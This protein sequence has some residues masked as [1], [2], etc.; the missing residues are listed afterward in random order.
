[1]EAEKF[2]QAAQILRHSSAK[3]RRRGF[4][5]EQTE[6]TEGTEKLQTPK[7]K[8]RGSTK[9]QTPIR[10]GDFTRGN[11]GN[12]E[13][14]RSSEFQVSPSTIEKRRVSLNICNRRH[15]NC[16]QNHKYDCEL[17]EHRYQREKHPTDLATNC[18]A[19]RP[20]HPLANKQSNYRDEKKQRPDKRCGRA[21][22]ME[23]VGK[24]Q[25]QKISGRAEEDGQP[26]DCA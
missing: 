22:D 25:Q 17:E 5:Q 8:L 16:S 11:G 15:K 14:G 21:W 20:H 24:K 2:A 18:L 19:G 13:G 26:N 1:M 6:G 7:S 3:G 23:L 12:G 4:E 9:I 10:T